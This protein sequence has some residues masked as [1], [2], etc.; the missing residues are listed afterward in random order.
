MNSE[1]LTLCSSPNA[2]CCQGEFN[3]D[4]DVSPNTLTTIN[5]LV[6]MRDL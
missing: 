5:S 4:F 2:C 3:Y 1:M 6:N